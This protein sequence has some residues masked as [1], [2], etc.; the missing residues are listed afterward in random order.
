MA[1]NRR[2]FIGSLASFGAC[3]LLRAAPGMSADKPLLRFGVVS[4]IHM[5]L[6]KDGKTL[7]KGYDTETFEKALAWYRDEGVDAVVI[8][9]D[10]ADSGL[11]GE[12]KAVA[13]AWYRVFP[14][15][16]APDG[17]KVE[18][19]FVFGNH[20]AFGLK[21]GKKVFTD[22]ETLRREAIEVDPA[23]AWDSCF[24][25]EYKPFFVKNVKG[26]DFFCSHWKPGVWC[27]GHSEKGCSGCGDA[28][29]GL[30]ERCDP[31]RPFFYV[32]HPHPADT[33]Y[34]QGAWGVDDG[35]ASKLLSAFPQAVAF[36]GHSHLPLTNERSIWRGAY[37]SVATGSL[38]MLSASALWNR[39]H[40]PGYENGICNY[41]MP[42]VEKKD[43]PAYIAKY[44]APK[45][46]PQELVRPE[47]RVGQLVSVYGDRI[48][49]AKREFVSGLPLG[50]DWVVA[51]PAREMSFAALAK[52]AKPAEFPND[53]KLVVKCAEAKT[54]G[55]KKSKASVGIKPV[56]TAVL[57]LTFPAATMGG[58]VAEYEL[59]ATNVAGERYETRVCAI[60]GLYPRTHGNFSKAV[61][62]TVSVA[63]LPKGAE[64]VSVAPLDSYG[65][66]G[67][68]LSAAIPAVLVS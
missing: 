63:A 50:D 1:M 44:D 11:V 65:N 52:T 21:N 25:E 18:R 40:T 51:L 62:M 36:S 4:D 27:N 29:R 48:E 39:I 61:S 46:M 22:K 16:L 23:K 19:V 47:I 17:R 33:V 10:M 42:G 13:D 6:D 3:R 7:A 24:H 31:S 2:F 26:Y 20:D 66:K 49:F 30:M 53:A 67:R 59:S 60:G 56:R 38:R 28:F 64:K 34:G 32:Q 41:Y 5:R 35:A 45:T 58:Q 12:L 9:G 14:S 57:R 37:T 8:A 43:R 55:M 68:P 54:R 15:D